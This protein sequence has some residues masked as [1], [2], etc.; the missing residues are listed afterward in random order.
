VKAEAEAEAATS[1]SLSGGGFGHCDF[2]ENQ[3][4]DIFI[5]SD[6]T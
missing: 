3:Y 4:Q 6:S 2:F 5:V 1:F